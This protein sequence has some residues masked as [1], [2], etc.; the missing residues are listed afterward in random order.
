M[1]VLVV[2]V[3]EEGAR[4]VVD[5]PGRAPLLA[6]A[7]L[8]VRVALAPLCM[9]FGVFSQMIGA[10]E[11]LITGGAC[12]SLLSCVCAKMALKLVGAREALAAEEPVADEGPLPGVP[13][14]VRLQVRGLPVH[15]PAARDVAVVNVLLSQ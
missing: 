9:S 6:P 7:V 13:A 3:E 10:H 5:G 12:E 11:S 2:V 15:L 1:V 14:Q 4:G 8:R